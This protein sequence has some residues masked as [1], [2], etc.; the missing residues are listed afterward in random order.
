MKVQF[1]IAITDAGQIGLFAQGDVD[2]ATAKKVL[3]QLMAQLGTTDIVLGDIAPIEQHRDDVRTQV[4][5]DLTHH[6]H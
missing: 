1:R 4:V 6:K 2:A 5:H 3:A